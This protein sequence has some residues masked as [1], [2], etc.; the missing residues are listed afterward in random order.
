MSLLPL[1]LGG[2]AATPEPP[3]P[4]DWATAN[5]VFEGHSIVAVWN[6]LG[7]HTHTQQQTPGIVGATWANV[8]LP[9]QTWDQIRTSHSDTDAAWIAGKTNILVVME[10]INFLALSGTPRTSAQCITAA[11]R[12]LSSIRAARHWDRIVIL[13]SLPSGG[14][15]T[16]QVL[17]WPQMQPIGMTWA[18]VNQRQ[19]EF[20]AYVSTH[21]GELGA[22]AFVSFRGIPQFSGDGSTLTEFTSASSY[23]WEAVAPYVHPSNAGKAAMGAV[24]GEALLGL[25]L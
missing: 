15:P 19:D 20:D 7:L 21:L 6:M 1:L 25:T 3:Q 11:Q 24:I 16:S 13:G 8:G 2:Q 9:G 5:I 22:D 17:N 18:E 10:A 4:I 14:D 12:A 23:W